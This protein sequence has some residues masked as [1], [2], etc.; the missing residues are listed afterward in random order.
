MKNLWHVNFDD[1]K[2]GMTLISE[3]RGGGSFHSQVLFIKEK[4]EYS[5]IFDIITITHGSV[6]LQYDDWATKT[7]WENEV[8][9][10]GRIMKE[11]YE[12]RFMWQFFKFGLFDDEKAR[13]SRVYIRT[14]SQLLKI[15]LSMA[16]EMEKKYYEKLKEKRY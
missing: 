12:K 5:I 15:P 8:H 4:R 10:S 6:M 11:E 14:S 7:E 13:R 16:E 3:D 1:L 9:L 2:V